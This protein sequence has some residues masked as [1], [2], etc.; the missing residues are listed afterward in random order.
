MINRQQAPHGGFAR[1]SPAHGRNSGGQPAHRQVACARS[2]R[3]VP[4]GGGVA[5]SICRMI[6]VMPTGT[7]SSPRRCS[8]WRMFMPCSATRPSSPARRPGV[9]GRTATLSRRPAAGQAEVDAAADQ[10]QVGAAAADHDHGGRSAASGTSRRIRAAS[11]TAPAPSPR[12]RVRLRRRTRASAMASSSTVTMASTRPATTR[13][14]S[15][16]GT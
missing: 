2:V 11:S 8:T 1:P 5:V 9:S 16:P 14:V 7:C 10:G 3:A 13:R 4:P 6:S 12:V 15:S